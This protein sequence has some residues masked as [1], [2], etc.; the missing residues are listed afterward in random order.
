MMDERIT[1]RS[2]LIIKHLI[3]TSNVVKVTH[4]SNVFYIKYDNDKRII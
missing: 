1:F 3:D 4:F 2:P